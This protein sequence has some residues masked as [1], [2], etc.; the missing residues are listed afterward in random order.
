MIKHITDNIAE[1]ELFELRENEKQ[2]LAHFEHS[3]WVIC[4]FCG[5]GLL[6]NADYYHNKDAP[7]DVLWNHHIQSHRKQKI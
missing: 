7:L 4:A 1:F 2:L 3:D 5:I 6:Y